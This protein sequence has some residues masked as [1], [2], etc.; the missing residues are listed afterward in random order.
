[1]EF[2]EEDYDEAE[3]KSYYYGVDGEFGADGLNRRNGIGSGG[4]FGGGLGIG[5]GG[6]MGLEG[7]AVLVSYSFA[8]GNG[9]ESGGVAVGVG[10]NGDCGGLAHG[11]VDVEGNVLAEGV[12]RGSR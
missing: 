5:L 2:E 10:L 1:M 6:G 7:G 8:V 9:G 4:F 12:S 3:D 11:V